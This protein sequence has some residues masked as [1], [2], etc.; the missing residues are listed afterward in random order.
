MDKI[1]LHCDCNSF[2]ASVEMV[3]DP[4]LRYVPMAVC[5][6]ERD[7][8]GIVLAKNELAK[9]CG[10]KTAETVH[11][12]RKKCPSLVIVPPDHGDYIRYS[13]RINEIY[14]RFTDTVE[15]F[16]IDESWLDVTGSAAIFGGGYETAEKISNA[17][18]KEIGVTL[19]IGVSFSKIYAKLGS[20]YKKPDAITVIDRS[21]YRDIVFPMDVENL[22]FVGGKTALKLKESGI[23]TIGDLASAGNEF[24]RELLGK[25]GEALGRYANGIDDG[26]VVSADMNPDRKSVSNGF[27]FSR[28][29]VTPEE[30]RIAIE[31][32]SDR[33]GT[34]L[35]REGMKCSTVSV[36]VKNVQLRDMTKQRALPSPTDLSKEIAEAA[37]SVMSSFWSSDA[38]VRSIT[39][40]A[41]NLIKASD[42]HEQIDFFSDGSD[43]KRRK[44]EVKERSVD[45]IKKRFGS[46]SLMRASELGSNFGIASSG[47]E[48]RKKKEKSGRG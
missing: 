38:P 23:R 9:Q 2:Y 44:I 4:S 6:S 18:K 29:L 17:V 36:N 3:K 11:S 41:S 5:G 8:H 16:G 47:S 12:A 1:I 14:Y 43:E 10:I 45:D 39:V 7:R 34:V 30:Y 40:S 13:R 31:Y 19:S 25:N 15:P 20:D 37:C 48:K 21:N 26:P 22:L 32:L 24:L 46:G 35:K 33:I 42:V 28:D 27:T